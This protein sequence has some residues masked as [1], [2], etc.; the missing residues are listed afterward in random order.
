MVMRLLLFFSIATSGWVAGHLYVG[1][2][3]FAGLEGTARKRAFGVFA[4]LGALGPLTMGGGRL[5][6]EA[7]WFVPV[8]WAGFI[9]MGAFTLVFFLVLARDLLRLGFWAARRGKGEPSNLE[10]RLFLTNAANA[11]LVSVAGAM[12]AWGFVEAT[13]EPELEEVDVPIPGLPSELDGYRIAQVSDI[14]I[15]PTIKGD[16]LRSVVAR[17]NA[18]GA[19]VIAVTGD[20]VDGYVA[21]LRE[22][23]APL[24]DLEARDGV[25]FVTGNH[26]YYWGAEEWIA[27]VRQLGL[28]ALLNEHRVITRGDK[29]LL[30]AG[31]TDYRAERMLPEHKSDPAG[32]RAGAPECDLSVLLAH[33]PKSG[34]AASRAGYDLQLS[35]HTH[36]GQFFPITMFVGL[37]HPV[38]EGL[39]RIGDMLVYVNRGTGYWGP[40]M[41]T[42]AK[43]EIT[44]LTLRSA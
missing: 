33:Q 19:D 3:L 15:G 24:G 22:H 9:Y 41:R 29:K 36:G 23:V 39:G 13:R 6:S 2:R 34:I 32:A 42:L 38:S 1:R 8:R 40:P 35:G 10:R 37:A 20:L 26:E 27:E 30:L 28:T 4:V 25:Y 31:C 44:L 14:H 16:F 11:S 12:T 17:V 18:L 7:A 5:F 43:S 21:E